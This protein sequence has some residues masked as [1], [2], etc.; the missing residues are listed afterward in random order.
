MHECPMIAPFS[1]SSDGVNMEHFISGLPF[2][3]SERIKDVGILRHL[4]GILRLRGNQQ[5][6]NKQGGIVERRDGGLE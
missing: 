5:S 2:W 4:G 1:S 6:K 3:T